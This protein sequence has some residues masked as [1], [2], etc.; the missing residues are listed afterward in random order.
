M[1]ITI[2]NEKRK[3][4]IFELANSQ[5]KFFGLNEIKKFG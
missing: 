5:R 2:V 3:I 1:R 4:M